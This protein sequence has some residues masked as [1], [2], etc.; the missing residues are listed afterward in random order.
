MKTV[1]I[2]S[3]AYPDCRTNRNYHC[4]TKIDKKTYTAMSRLKV[5]IKKDELNQSKYPL[6]YEILIDTELEAFGIPKPEQGTNYYIDNFCSFHYFIDE[7]PEYQNNTSEILE[8]KEVLIKAHT[9][10]I[11]HEE[12][13]QE[14]I[15]QAPDIDFA[16]LNVIFNS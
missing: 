11:I 7:C 4:I 3:E 12:P 13:N 1:Y 5:K 8:G 14:L 15:I 6:S 10:E 9:I 2:L 16:F